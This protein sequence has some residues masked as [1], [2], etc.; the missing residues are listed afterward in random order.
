[1]KHRAQIAWL[2]MAFIAYPACGTRCGEGPEA[3]VAVPW[4]RI[5]S[6]DAQK[7]G[8]ALYLQNCALCHGVAADGRGVRSMGLEQKPADFAQGVWS[9]PDAPARAYRAI[10]EGVAGTAMPSWS[11][12][13]EDET[14]DLV[15]YLVSVSTRGAERS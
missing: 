10:R 7:R 9:R 2:V 12:L 1:M 15:A 8:R 4:N 3:A 5:Q 14:W 6:A 11:A 13:S